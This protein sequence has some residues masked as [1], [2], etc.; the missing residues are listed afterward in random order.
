MDD[1]PSDNINND[2][3]IHSYSDCLNNHY[4][5]IISQYHSTPHMLELSIYIL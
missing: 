4:M 2:V 1:K 5:L 3:K